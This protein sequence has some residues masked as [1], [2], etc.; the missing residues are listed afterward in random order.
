MVMGDNMT[1]TLFP[2]YVTLSIA[3]PP[4]VSPYIMCYD[5]GVF[6]PFQNL[7]RSNRTSHA[8]RVDGSQK[9]IRHRFVGHELL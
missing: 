9:A 3:T 7:S 1:D 6:G 4:P 2:T 5:R 8:N